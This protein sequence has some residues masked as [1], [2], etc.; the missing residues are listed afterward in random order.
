[1]AAHA[2]D[3][4]FLQIRISLLLHC[5]PLLLTLMPSAILIE[6]QVLKP[7]LAHCWK[8]ICPTR[9]CSFTR[10]TDVT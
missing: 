8:I 4:C 9:Y 2:G 3:F 6:I 5:L 7:L 1:M 10:T